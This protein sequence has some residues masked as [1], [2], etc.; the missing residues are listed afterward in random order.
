MRS[1]SKWG[2]FKGKAASKE[3]LKHDLFSPKANLPKS[4]LQRRFN[5]ESCSVMCQFP[6]KDAMISNEICMSK[7]ITKTFLSSDFLEYTNYEM[8]QKN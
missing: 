4:A 5:A 7:S 8:S 3:R 1:S 6:Y 2:N